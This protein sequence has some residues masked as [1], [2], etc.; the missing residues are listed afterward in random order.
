M[1]RFDYERSICAQ[2]RS[3]KGVAFRDVSLENWS[4]KPADCHENVRKWAD[5]HPQHSAIHG[6]VILGGNGGTMLAAHSVV[7]DENGA[8]FDI[9]PIKD[10]DRIR[11]TMRF[12]VHD[13]DERL[14]LE[15]LQEG[16]RNIIYCPGHSL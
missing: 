5:A 1:S 7:Q 4:L 14:F 11:P 15:M 8:L 13:G 3:A 12:I 10:E 16:T 9:T 2:L 6:W